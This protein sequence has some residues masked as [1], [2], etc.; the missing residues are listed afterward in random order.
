MRRG[1]FTLALWGSYLLHERYAVRGFFFGLSP[2]NYTDTL[3]ESYGDPRQ[4]GLN[5]S[6]AF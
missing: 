6:A 3:Y 5:L 4:L 1:P 2:P